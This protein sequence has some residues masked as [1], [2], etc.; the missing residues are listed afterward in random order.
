MRRETG[1]R[2][3][4][5]AFLADLPAPAGGARDVSLEWPGKGAWLEGGLGHDE[6][7]VPR[8]HRDIEGEPQQVARLLSP[9]LLPVWHMLMKLHCAGRRSAKDWLRKKGRKLGK[10]STVD[11][12][13]RYGPS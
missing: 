7:A 5:A 3:D 11:L 6:R 12:T 1:I 4:T 13:D 8:F 2:D 9:K 10:M